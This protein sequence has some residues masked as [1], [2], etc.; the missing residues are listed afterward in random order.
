M[1][2]SVKSWTAPP[3]LAL[4]ARR[5]WSIRAHLALFAALLLVPAILFSAYLINRSRAHQLA[6]AEGRV[7]Q[8][9]VDLADDISNEL[10]RGVTILQTLALSGNLER[11]EYE[12]LHAHAKR[13]LEG[14]FDVFL[15]L[16]PNGRQIVNTFEPYGTA[17]PSYGDPVALAKAVETRKPLVTDLFHGR[18]RKAWVINILYPVLSD[19]H[20]HRVLV[21]SLTADRIR[22][23]L[24]AQQLEGEWTT[25]VSD[26][27]HILIAR[28]RLH[29][30][31]VGKSL[32]PELIEASHKLKVPHRIASVDGRAIVRAVANTRLADWTVAAAVNEA[33]LYAG[34]R[35][36]SRDL[37]LAGLALLAISA[38]LVGFLGQR[39]ASSMRTLARPATGEPVLSSVRE[40]NEAAALLARAMGEVRQRNETLRLALSSGYAVAFTW[41]IECNAVVRLFSSEPGLA[42]TEH[43]A[44]TFEGVEKVVHPEDRATFRS[45]VQAALD[46][47]DRHYRNAYRLVRPD[48]TIRWLEERG[49]VERRSDNTPVRLVGI[50]IDVTDNKLAAMEVQRSERRFR[51]LADSMPQLVWTADAN[52]SVTY[53]NQR[54]EEYRTKGIVAGK[55][56]SLI[57]ADDLE[58]TRLAWQHAVETCSDYECEHRVMRADGS[59]RWQLSRA[60]PFRHEQ[61]TVWYGTATDIH[62]LKEREERINQL[63]KEVNHRSKNLLAVVL[64]VARQTSRAGTPA[65]FV[66]RLTSRVQGLSASQDLLVKAEWRGVDL[67]ELIRAQLA[68]YQDLVD[69]RIRLT[70][71]ALR[72]EAAAAQVI[73]MAL[74]ELVTNAAI[75]GALAGSGMV[76]VDW[77]VAQEGVPPQFRLSWRESGGPAISRPARQ[78]FGHTVLMRTTEHAL[79][80]RCALDF[81]ESGMVWTLTAPL[82]RVVHSQA[83]REFALTAGGAR[84]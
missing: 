58:R 6:Q 35:T 56:Q 39:F 17:L 69:T 4:V 28:T 74:H 76:D 63:L 41:D 47:P 2:P 24:A 1:K 3:T 34:A 70:G 62:D 33:G 29:E 32:T 65:E 9:A 14:R 31:F 25:G 27:N 50:S 43:G 73:G 16:E 36:S 22:Q 54:R 51:E 60:K 49:T 12:V 8:L 79:G 84:G 59:Y 11:G 68:P 52:G 15:L 64:S 38:G 71:P 18:T 19:E 46:E 57:H 42:P 26:S 40:A 10:E 44:D 77:Q 55:W 78:G 45:N 67:E 23:I 81:P 30:E 7:V 80:G 66:D 61:G 82:D 48:G 21:L 37:A 20:V 75:H 13:I 72:L 5:E 53:F 83:D